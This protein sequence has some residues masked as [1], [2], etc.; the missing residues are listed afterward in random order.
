MSETKTRHS[1]Y[2]SFL[3]H[4]NSVQVY[5][6]NI[7]FR[8]KRRRSS[9]TRA[10]SLS[11]AIDSARHRQQLRSHHEVADTVIL[12]FGYICCSGVVIIRGD[13]DMRQAALTKALQSLLETATPCGRWNLRRFCERQSRNQKQ[14]GAQR[15]VSRYLRW[16][17]HIY[18]YCD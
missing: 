6:H 2:I 5:I 3:T 18:T 7:Q 16:I 11:A 8:P 12:I 15:Y 4:S 13:L 1:R 14:S 9:L 17:G 10:R